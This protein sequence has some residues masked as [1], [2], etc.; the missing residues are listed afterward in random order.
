MYYLI[1]RDLDAD[2]QYEFIKDMDKMILTEDPASALQV[3]E[4]QLEYIDMAY[5]NAAGFYALEADRFQV[6][7][8]EKLLFSPIMMGYR[9][10]VAPPRPR[11]RMPP[12][13]PRRAP[14]RPAPP[15]PGR[16]P[17]G[18]LGAMFAPEPKRGRR[19]DGPKPA[20][21][22]EG[23]GGPRGERGRGPG[24]GRKPGGRGPGR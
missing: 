15:R 7:I 13:P 21:R 12:P 6:S 5:L 14:R 10:P 19:P 20:P 3:S 8:L 4:E 1:G 22:P 24:A 17:L 9:P 23:P 2:G 18:M 11:R 16:S